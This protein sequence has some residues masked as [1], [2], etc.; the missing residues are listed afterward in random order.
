[1]IWITSF[2]IGWGIAIYWLLLGR[3]RFVILMS[4]GHVRVLKGH[5]PESF[6]SICETTSL[7]IPEEH[8][9]IIRGD[10]HSGQVYLKMSPHVEET[11]RQQLRNNFPYSAYGRA[12]LD[13]DFPRLDKPGN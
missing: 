12:R 1:M 5:V 2:I 11:I 4:K 8:R 13:W 10:Q 3:Y 7:T 6:L 9:V